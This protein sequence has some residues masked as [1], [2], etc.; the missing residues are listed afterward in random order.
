MRAGHEITL[1]CKRS[2]VDWMSVAFQLG[3]N[4]QDQGGGGEDIQGFLRQS[5]PRTQRDYPRKRAG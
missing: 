4:E 1:V 2:T 3:R 5:G